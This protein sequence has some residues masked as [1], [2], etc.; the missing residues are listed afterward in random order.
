MPHERIISLAHGSG[1][2]L[3]HDLIRDTLRS[4]FTNTILDALGDSACLGDL[5]MSGNREVCFTTDSFVVQPLFFP[6]GDIGKL[7]VCG[8]VNDLAMEGAEPLFLSCA[9]I[10]EEGLDMDNLERAADSM[11]R[12][13]KEAGVRIVTGDFKVVE[14]GKGDGLFINTSG[15]GVRRKGI[16]PGLGGIQPG[17]RILINGTLGD[18]GLAV[19]AARN[20]FDIEIGAV[21]DCAALNSLVRAMLTAGEGLRF[22]R[23][24]TRGGLAATLN[25]MTESGGFGITIEENALPLRDETRAACEILG[26]DPLHLANEG[27]VVVCASPGNAQAILE[28]MR[29]HP[30]GREAR[31]IGAVTPEPARR[32]V[33]RT[34]SGGRRVLDMPA[35]ELYPRIC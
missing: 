20:L 34:A 28:A 7:S 2:R 25:E 18:H 10:A 31:D 6:G 14:R 5:G 26:M 4:R 30:L 16:L 11:A 19:L 27:K 29:R 17:D 33:I 12:T 9:M 15:V 13:A 3:M 24:P 21:S 23:D 32:V 8:T 22:M 35:G 1:G